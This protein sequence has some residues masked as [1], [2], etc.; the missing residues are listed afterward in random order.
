[1]ERSLA[2]VVTLVEEGV[3][4]QEKVIARFASDVLGALIYLQNM[5]IAHRDLRSDNLLLNKDGVLKLADFSN[6]LKVTPQSPT[7]SGVVGVIYWQAPEVWRGSYNPLKADVWS[8]GATVWE[9]A[10]AEPP[11]HDAEDASGLRDRWPSL[12]QPEIYTRSFHDFLHLCSN[13]VPNRPD[14][15]PLLSTPFIR[16]AAKRSAVVQLLAECKSIEDALRAQ[17]PEGGSDSQGTISE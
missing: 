13:P 7:C 2:D 14:P 9:M 5:G 3:T 16:S 11:F 6:A 12:R 4:I 8:L 15:E 10:Q 17:E 1:M